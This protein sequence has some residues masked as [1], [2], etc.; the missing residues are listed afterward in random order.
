MRKMVWAAAVVAVAA[1]SAFLLI[2]GAPAADGAGKLAS[3]RVADRVEKLRGLKFKKQPKVQVVSQKELESELRKVGSESERELKGAARD[4]AEGLALSAELVSTM[5][6]LIDYERD[7]EVLQREGEVGVAGLYVPERDRIYVI[8]EIVEKDRK[9]GE[10]VL[11]HELTHALED[12][13]FGDFER[14][15]KPFADSAFARHALHEGSATLNELLYR[16]RYQRVQGP[17]S[18]LLPLVR[19]STSDPKAPPGMNTMASFPYAD[20]GAFAAALHEKGGWDTVNKAHRN[21]PQTTSAILHPDAWPKDRHERPRF[22]VA[23]ELGADWDRLGRADIGEIDTLA[24]LSAGLPA[25]EARAGADGWEAGRFEAWAR[26]TV[27]KKCKPPCRKD[28]AAVLVWRMRDAEQAKELS[29]ALAKALAKSA[30]AKEQDGVLAFD[31]GAGA[32]L[33]KGRVAVLAFAPTG[34]EA[35]KLA[36]AAPR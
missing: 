35:K 33:T 31:G 23:D 28:T 34:G 10:A 11:A 7:K 26:K 5:T 1:I 14:D 9:E 20:G 30:G 8:E 4:R 36:A 16:I 15:P 22:T 25:E 19:K 2:G 13:T 17:P 6:G 29:G 27:N 3:E 12:Q 21:P 32:Q 18:K 24:I